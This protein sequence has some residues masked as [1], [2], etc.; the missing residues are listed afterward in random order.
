VDG[1]HLADCDAAAGDL[2]QDL[3]SVLPAS[4]L[5]ASPPSPSAVARP[6]VPPATAR[7]TT[8]QSAKLF[9]TPVSQ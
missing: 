9:A 1:L 7:R 5:G 8:R 2:L 4:V 3:F 6:V